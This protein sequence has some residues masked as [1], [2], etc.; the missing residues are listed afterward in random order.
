EIGN[1]SHNPQQPLEQ[2]T[3]ELNLPGIEPAQRQA[4]D[5]PSLPNGVLD[6]DAVLQTVAALMPEHAILCD[7]TISS[8]RNLLAITAGAPAHDVLPLNGG[9]IGIGLPLATG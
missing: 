7:E 2:I 9:A 3:R 1:L 8:G 6:A 5:R 4:L